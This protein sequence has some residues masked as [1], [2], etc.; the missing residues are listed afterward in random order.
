MIK[1]FKSAATFGVFL[2]PF[3]MTG[4]ATIVSGTTQK[5]SVT[6]QPSG[7]DAKVDNIT[8][9]KTPAVFTLERKNDHTLEISKE[10]YKTATIMF[11]KTF[12]GMTTGNILIG[13]IIGTGIDA[14][15][16][17]MNKIIPERV[18]V[19]LESGTGYSSVPKFASEKDAEFYEKSIL[20]SGAVKAADNVVQAPSS[21]ASSMQQAGGTLSP[22]QGQPKT[23]F[24][25]KSSSM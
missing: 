8:S 7:A 20:K 2:L 24:G 10:G 11:K 23:N 14:A 1:L 17:S 12:N 9:A 4:C 22:Q 18:D 19:I 21:Q 3:L 5:V 16:G 25:P 15:S 6:S 13:G